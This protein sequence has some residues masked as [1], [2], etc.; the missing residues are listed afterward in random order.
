MDQNVKSLI[1]KA[2][3]A[4]KS[5]DAMRYSQA[6][7]NAAHSLATLEDIKFREMETAALKKRIPPSK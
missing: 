7:L 2:A 6:A 3:D 4:E 5:E 1:E